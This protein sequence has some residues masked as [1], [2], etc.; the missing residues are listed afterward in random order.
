MPTDLSKMTGPRANENHYRCC[1]EYFSNA[2]S[3]CEAAFRQLEYGASSATPLTLSAH[4]LAD[5]HTSRP[6]AQA[7][8][9]CRT[10]SRGKSTWGR[11]YLP[12]VLSF[13]LFKLEP[14]SFQYSWEQNQLKASSHSSS[15]RERAIYSSIVRPCGKVDLK[16]VL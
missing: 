13:L 12:G 8:F 11:K 1:L 2:D 16:V 9:T 6:Q 4:Y 14:Q 10:H 15:L 7:S 3:K 5:G